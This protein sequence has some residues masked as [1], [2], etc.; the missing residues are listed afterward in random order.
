MRRIVLGALVLCSVGC[1]DDPIPPSWLAVDD[2]SV[3]GKECTFTPRTTIG[4]GGVDTQQ[5]GRVRLELVEVAADPI[6]E[7]ADAT[8][9]GC[10]VTRDLSANQLGQS[11]TATL[12]GECRRR[13]DGNLAFVS[14]R[15]EVTDPEV[16]VDDDGGFR[17][18]MSAPEALGGNGRSHLEMHIEQ[19]EREGAARREATAN[20]PTDRVRR[21][22][23][24]V[25]AA[26]SAFD[27]APETLPACR[28]LAEDLESIDDWP[29]RAELGLLRATIAGEPPPD[30]PASRAGQSAMHPLQMLARVEGGETLSDTQNEMMQRMDNGPDWI[31]VIEVSELIEPL[32]VGDR[33]TP[34]AVAAT[35][36]LVDPERG[37]L[38]RTA[39]RHVLEAESMAT[40]SAEQD[41][42]TDTRVVR[43][44]FWMEV[45]QALN[46]IAPPQNP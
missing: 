23:A 26:A 42:E 32:V 28:R 4:L 15:Y 29:M 11:Q 10:S 43:D 40:A 31:Q 25:R 20:A 38:C 2:W 12:E 34:G 6:G 39:F 1:E 3:S 16:H 44:N 35:V 21:L 24:Q 18:L 19:S 27:R 37:A 36:T 22:A 7:T 14:V 41:H 9:L 17:Q 45:S 13:S 5:A 30:T 46:R 8:S 33:Y